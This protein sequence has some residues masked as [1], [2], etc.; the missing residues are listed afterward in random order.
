VADT[1]ST[2]SSCDGSLSAVISAL[3]CSVPI[4][5][6]SS[7]PFSLSVSTLIVV[8]VSATNSEG[9]GATSPENTSG[10]TVKTVPV[11][12][13]AVYEGT[14]S[15]STSIV[16][17][18]A[19]LTST[20]DTGDSA[21]TTYN[22]YW[23]D[24]T[25]TTNIYLMDSLVTTYT[26]T[27]LTTGSDYIFKVSASN[28]YG[29]GDFSA[30]ATFTISGVP[31]TIDPV[32]TA[33]SGT[34][35]EIHISWVEPSGNGEAVLDFNIE[36][37]D[38][39]T[40][41]FQEETTYCD[42]TTAPIKDDDEC[43]V[44]ITF[45]ISSYGYVQGEIVY[46][47]VRARNANGYSSYSSVNTGGQTIQ[48]EP[49]TMNT[50]Y[51]DGSTSSTIVISWAAL[52]GDIPTGGTPI[53][54][55]HLD[56]KV[57]AGS[58][59]EIQGFSS[60]DTSTSASILSGLTEGTSYLFR[61]R[62]LNAIGWGSYSATV[63]IIPSEEPDKVDPPTVSVVGSNVKIEWNVPDDH[64]AAITAYQIKV[65]ESDDLTYSESA[66]CDGTATSVVTNALCF[67]PMTA[68]HSS[69]FSLP[70]DELIEVIVRAENS[71]GWGQF[72]DPNTA[73]GNDKI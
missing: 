20:S 7:A 49:A 73:A 45:L 38:M 66:Y 72:S 4:L 14:G 27:G 52:T 31:D 32:T 68:L 19:A 55:Y 51:D 10:A 70:Y 65:L 11:Q 64:G 34:N 61:V 9:P 12:M 6:F 48:T 56:W 8:R 26:V 29:D 57:G 59:T 42:G 13:S 40:L 67:I 16:L 35:D 21:I 15:T 30:D 25:G 2:T 54:S 43:F 36:V 69:P 60:V 58:W 37:L 47:R 39:S 41:D 24:N 3:S 46:A 71:R 5:E 1:F 23:D 44:P 33:L 63:T 28:F 50:P 18:W 17:E 62:A 53:T 22:L